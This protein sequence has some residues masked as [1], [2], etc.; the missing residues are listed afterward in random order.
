MLILPGSKKYHFWIQDG[1][2]VEIIKQNSPL[3]S[4][5]TALRGIFRIFITFTD[6]N[7]KHYVPGKRNI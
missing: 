3:I 6:S 7:K 5:S 2:H 4:L 1:R